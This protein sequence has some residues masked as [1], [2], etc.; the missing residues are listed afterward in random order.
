MMTRYVHNKTNAAK[1][2]SGQEVAANSYYE[3]PANLVFDF[4][5]DDALLAD[6]TS[7]DVAISKDGATDISGISNQ[8]DFLKNGVQEPRDLANRQIVRFAATVDGWH[9]SLL[10][11]EI[12]TAKKDGF[13][14][15]DESGSDVGFVTHKIYDGNGAEITDAANEGQAIETRV[16][17]RPTHDFEVIGAIFGQNAAPASDMRLWVT[18]L[19]G[20]YNIKFARGGINLRFAGDGIYQ[21]ADGRAS[22]YLA[23]NSQVP[24]ANAFKITVKHPQGTQHSFQISFEIYKAV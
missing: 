20:I 13:Y 23:Y 5:I 12:T 11:T 21:L 10:S 7:G 17:V 3:I 8:I 1:T 19:P 14:C 18:G 15:K 22:K 16:W 9:Y 6:I 4:S 2:Y 24:D